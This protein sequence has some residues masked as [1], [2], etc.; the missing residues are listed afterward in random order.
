MTPAVLAEAVE[1]LSA[2]GAD[3][4]RQEAID[5]FTELRA[6]LSAGAVR[7]AEPDASARSGWKVNAWVKRGILLGFL[8]RLIGGPVDPVQD[9]L[10]DLRYAFPCE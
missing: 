2:A 8:F 3:A 6:A 1:R 10:L 4:P 5:T 9:F 7:A